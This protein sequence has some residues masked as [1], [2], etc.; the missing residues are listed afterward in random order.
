MTSRMLDTY[1]VLGFFHNK[2]NT[3]THRVRKTFLVINKQKRQQNNQTAPKSLVN[4]FRTIDASGTELKNYVFL[5][6]LLLLWVLNSFPIGKFCVEIYVNVCVCLCLWLH[7]NR[8]C[9]RQYIRWQLIQF[10]NVY[11]IPK[12]RPRMNII[13]H[14]HIEWKRNN[15][16]VKHVQP[17]SK[18][19]IKIAKAVE[20]K[21][22]K[23]KLKDNEHQSWKWALDW[24]N[25]R[26]QI[27]VTMCVT[28]II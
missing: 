10:P 23:N 24:L 16:Y 7:Q 28:V 15:I 6:S 20:W 4:I 21:I 22:K 11:N 8:N 2:K 5:L 9:F 17:G 18:R 26:Q 3:L 25:V 1:D 12:I 14:I 13:T 19:T 27:I